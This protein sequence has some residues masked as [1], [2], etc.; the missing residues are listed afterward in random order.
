MSFCTTEHR[1]AGRVIAN[2][3]VI[4]N[5]TEGKQAQDVLRIIGTY[6][7]SGNEGRL[8]SEKV[9]LMEAAEFDFAVAGA[10]LLAQDARRLTA[11]G[12]TEL[13]QSIFRDAKR[14]ATFRSQMGGPE[15]AWMKASRINL[16]L[17]SKRSSRLF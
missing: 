12:V 6:A 17:Y 13:I 3:F 8:Y 5:K 14:I 7:E 10:H 16:K 4:L 2:G 11:L 1:L 15:F 9:E